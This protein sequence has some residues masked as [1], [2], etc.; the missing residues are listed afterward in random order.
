VFSATRE[1]R[2]PSR[3]WRVAA[4]ALLASLVLLVGAE[5]GWGKQTIRWHG[6]GSDFP[7][8]LQC[9]EL[10]VPLDY[11]RPRGPAIN[12]GFA[13]LP[14]RDRAHRVG[15]LIINPGGP[16][17]PGSQVVALE[18]AGR[19][20]WHPAL[21]RRFDL[22]GMDP[23]GIG[24][25]SPIQCDPATW[26]QPVS[27]FPRNPLE[28]TQLGSYVS[29]VGASCLDRTGPLLGHVDTL[30]VTRDMEALRRA[31]GDR[32]LNFLGLSY[33]AEIGMLYAERYPTRI[34]AMALDGIL[35]HSISTQRVFLEAAAAYED[36]FNRFAAWCGRARSCALHGRDVPAVFDRLVRRADRQPIPAPRCSTEPCRPTVT[37]AEIRLNSFNPLAT[38]NAI[39]AIGLPGWKG[40]A[41]A[42]AQAERGDASAF[43]SHLATTPKDDPFPGLAVNCVDYPRTVTTY[44]DFA[45]L[46]RRGRAIAPHTQG[47]SEAW[48]GVTGCMR[49]PVPLANPPHRPVIRGAP[50]ILLVS[51]RHDPSTSYVWARRALRQIP[52]AVLLT[53]AG[54]GHTSSWLGAHSRTNDAIARYLITRKSPPPSSVYPN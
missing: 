14:A 51:A 41:A 19:H 2:R 6:C 30:S 9:G 36:T 22:I 10:S 46:A 28:F 13:R 23:R 29:A 7:P 26:N 52:R 48:L 43:A 8:S 3:V 1:F 35:D 40:F 11:A 47:A 16:G 24:T 37:G 44:R 34:R 5:P 21:N 54:D 15:S 32:K 27:L 42:L 39:P 33:G 4:P 12:V 20:L 17:G 25:S 45:A 31:L 38:K 53:R 18:A 49:W 50:P